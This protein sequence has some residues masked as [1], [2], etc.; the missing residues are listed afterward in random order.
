MSPQIL[1]HCPFTV[2]K[3]ATLSESPGWESR[4]KSLGKLRQEKRHQGFLLKSF[5]FS[6]YSNLSHKLER[7]LNYN[8]FSYVSLTFRY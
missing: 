3:I 6:I 1:I 2:G 7:P 4:G 5:S 8:H